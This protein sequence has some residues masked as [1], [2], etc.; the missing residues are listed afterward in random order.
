MRKRKSESNFNLNFFNRLW[1]ID[2]CLLFQFSVILKAWVPFNVSISLKIDDYKP[3]DD[4]LNGKR[5]EKGRQ[6]A[7]LIYFFSI[8][9]V[10]GTD[11]FCFSVVWIETFWYQIHS[12]SEKSLKKR[13]WDVVR[14]LYFQ[15]GVIW[16]VKLS[17]ILISL[18]TD[19]CKRRNDILVGQRREKDVRQ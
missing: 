8:D 7:I 5:W 13:F 4:K 17:W 11:A 18:K 12:K 10:T 3:R 14:G 6:A 1:D 15:F 9:L 16:K 2:K 19:Y